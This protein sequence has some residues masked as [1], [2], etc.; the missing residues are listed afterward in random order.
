MVSDSGAPVGGAV[1]EICGVLKALIKRAAG[2]IGNDKET[3][4]DWKNVR[5]LL[6]AARD[7]VW[8]KKTRPRRRK[9]EG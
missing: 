8:M 7:R 9:K 1:I 4:V 3:K 2:L 6:R 5:F